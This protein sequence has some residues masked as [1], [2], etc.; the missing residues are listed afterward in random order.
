MNART[1]QPFGLL[2]DRQAAEVGVESCIGHAYVQ[3]VE[4]LE[5]LEVS[6]PEK[7]QFLELKV[8]D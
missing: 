6:V 7:D 1:N 3:P 2:T 4:V 8:A 5:K